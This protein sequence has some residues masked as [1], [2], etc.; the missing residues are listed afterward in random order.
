MTRALVDGLNMIIKS[1]LVAQLQRKI[2]LTET[3]K[4]TRRP[5][6]ARTE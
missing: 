5:N 4:S 1:F 2:L 6:E 3:R